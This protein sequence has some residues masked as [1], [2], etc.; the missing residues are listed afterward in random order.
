MFPTGHICSLDGLDGLAALC[1]DCSRL[2][3]APTT[4]HPCMPSSPV[5]RDMLEHMQLLCFRYTAQ[6]HKLQAQ[7]LAQDLFA[8]PEFQQTFRVNGGRVRPYA[9][10]GLVARTCSAVH[11]QPCR[12]PSSTSSLTGVQHCLVSPEHQKHGGREMSALVTGKTDV[13]SRAR[14]GLLLCV[15]SAVCRA[16]SEIWHH[17]HTVYFSLAPPCDE[18]ECWVRLA[19]GFEGGLYGGAFRGGGPTGAEGGARH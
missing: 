11:Q 12:F 16:S 15:L 19:G 14:T 6:Y 4:P 1:F 2:I 18:L 13:S 9:T 5:D 17:K 3:L 7:Q 10:H 8:S